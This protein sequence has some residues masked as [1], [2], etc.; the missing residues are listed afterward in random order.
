MNVEWQD[1]R[2]NIRKGERDFRRAAPQ[3]R[4]YDAATQ[5]SDGSQKL[6]AQT[7]DMRMQLLPEYMKPSNVGSHESML[8]PFWYAVEFDF[9]QDPTWTK[10]T[11]S[12]AAFNVTQEAGFI[13]LGIS[14]DAVSYGT[15]GELAPLQVQFQDRQSTRQFCNRP[16]SLLQFG[17][18]AKPTWLPIPMYLVPNSFLDVTVTALFPTF[19][20][21][22][23]PPETQL[24]KGN[25]LHTF[26]FFGYRCRK[27]TEKIIQDLI[28][29]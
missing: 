22:P 24:T 27:L 7:Q 3:T 6:F 2:K 14:R 1:E 4:T 20:T 9:G 11:R 12:T 8:W 19:N 13:L 25:G 28:F 23:P 26:I 15:A 29:K 16:V 10:T 18:S 5:N 21:V 17:K